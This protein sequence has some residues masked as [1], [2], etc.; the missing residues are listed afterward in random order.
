MTIKPGAPR[1]SGPDTDFWQARFEADATPWDRGAINPQLET[2]VRAGRLRPYA[3][4]DA[5]PAG[6]DEPRLTRVLIPGC[7]AGYEVGLLA[8]WGFDVT[9]VDYAPAAIARTRDRL[10][11]A[12]ASGGASRINRV[13]LIEADLLTWRPTA[14]FDAIYEQTCLCAMHPDQWR[15]Y[16]DRLLDWLRPG[17][18]LF[19]L[20][21]QALKPGAA[22]GFVE[23]PP[24][25]CDINAMRA[26]FPDEDW[27]WP[28]PAYPVVPHPM[29][30]REL[31]V[32][33]TRR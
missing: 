31:A 27:E 8:E 22:T 12:F 25:H 16:A 13:E 24:Y 33:L 11:K 1:R 15:D 14:L 32:V 28:K 18:Q 26:L 30:A 23:G 4:A 17:G 10:R 9:A 19:A 21:M 2:W 5:R 20:F 7:G 6:T 3:A 29:G